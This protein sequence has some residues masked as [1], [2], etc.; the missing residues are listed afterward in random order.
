[1]EIDPLSKPKVQETQDE[2]NMAEKLYHAYS[3]I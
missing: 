1:M 3:E 2:K